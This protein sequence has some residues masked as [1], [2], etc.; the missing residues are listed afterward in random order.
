VVQRSAGWQK[1]DADVAANRPAAAAFGVGVYVETDTRRVYYSDGAAWVEIGVLQFTNASLPAAAVAGRLVLDTDQRQLYRDTGA[2]LALIR[3]LPPGHKSGCEMVWTG[4]AG[5]T[6]NAGSWRDAADTQNMTLAASMAK[7][8]NGAGSWTAGAAGNA[9]PAGA[10]FGNGKFRVFLISKPDGTTDWGCDT[11]A[12]AANL[13]AAATGYTKY[14]RIGWIYVAG[15]NL[16][17]WIQHAN[18]PDLFLFDTPQ[19]GWTDAGDVDYTAGVTRAMTAGFVNTEM[20]AAVG[21]D[22]V[23][24]GSPFVL[25]NPDQT[26]GAA[27][28]TAAPGTYARGGDSG[29]SQTDSMGQVRIFLDA[30]AQVRAR[31]GDA[32]CR[33]NIFIHGW[34][35]ARLV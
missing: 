30:S 5:F 15:G 6:V 4:V 13:L 27:S 20:I 21:I 2:A 3:S 17:E 11:S 32:A 23:G 19:M 14:R 9:F 8:C 34:R 26:I 16:I 18:D 29:G 7:V 28:V 12:T 35:D 1:V 31:G 22:N 10:L 25:G 33:L 24:S